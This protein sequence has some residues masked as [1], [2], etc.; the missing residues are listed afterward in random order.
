MS[1]FVFSLRNSEIYKFYFCLHLLLLLFDSMAEVHLCAAVTRKIPDSV[2]TE[3]I[4][5][6]QLGDL[7][8]WGAREPRNFVETCVLLTLYK[9]LV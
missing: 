3:L 8:L 6:A 5:V 9:D 1:I 2:V 4:V 7:R